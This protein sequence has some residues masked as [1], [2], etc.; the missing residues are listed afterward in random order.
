MGRSNA[1]ARRRN[2]RMNRRE[3]GAPRPKTT[4]PR[5]AAEDLVIPDGQ[6]LRNPRKPKAKF[7]TPE[8]AATAL[9]QAQ[10]QRKR[11]GAGHMEKR[12]YPCLAE[13]GGCG[14][15]HLTSRESYDP[16]WKRGAS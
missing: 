9:R 4:I 5:V 12:Y 3:K 13:E 8:K 2:N 15:Y 11:S 14:G 10:A 16:L 1:A 6:C 7:N